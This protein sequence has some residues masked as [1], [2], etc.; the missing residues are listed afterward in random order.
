MRLG[1][2]VRIH[3]CLETTSVVRSLSGRERAKFGLTAAAQDKLSQE[4]TKEC[5]Q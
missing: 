3:V 1:V 4:E 5:S 2:A